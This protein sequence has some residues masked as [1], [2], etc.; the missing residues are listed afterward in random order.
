M[1]PASSISLDHRGGGAE[2]PRACRES[3]PNGV[4]RRFCRGLYNCRSLVVGMPAW[5]SAST[6]STTRA[7]GLSPPRFP[8]HRGTRRPPGDRQGSH[9]AGGDI[10]AAPAFYLLDVAGPAESEGPADDVIVVK[11]QQTQQRTKDLV[12]TIAAHRFNP[13]FANAMPRPRSR[14]AWIDRRPAGACPMVRNVTERAR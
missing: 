10:A 9:L 13:Y 3:A 4:S 14:P 7:Q 12:K 2:A 1:Y 6:A 5:P 8:G 11:S